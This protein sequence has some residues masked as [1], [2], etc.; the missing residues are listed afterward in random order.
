MVFALYTKG[1]GLSEL[2]V[3][4]FPWW[5]GGTR[6]KKTGEFNLIKDCL[7]TRSGHAH[8]LGIE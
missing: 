4:G 2:F 3:S 7:S 8:S 1:Y 5:F 6:Q